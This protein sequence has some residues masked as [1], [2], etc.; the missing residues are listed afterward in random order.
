M[1]AFLGYAG[2]LLRRSPGTAGRVTGV[3][4][5]PLFR[6]PPSGLPFYAPMLIA[7]DTLI[8]VNTVHATWKNWRMEAASDGKIPEL[9]PWQTRVAVCALELMTGTLVAASLLIHRSRTA[10]LL[11]I[12][13]PQNLKARPS[14]ANRRIFIQSAGN[15]R[16]NGTIFPLSICNLTR[17]DKKVLFLQVEG[18]YGGW[19][20]N[21]DDGATVEGNPLIAAADIE[22]A[23]RVVGTQWLQAGGKGTILTTAT[24]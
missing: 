18:Q 23:C 4:K 2:N 14:A 20:F 9:R 16:A 12:L 6:R 22:K 17:V 13:P 11:S 7:A 24:L 1:A 10:T 5:A 8:I 15:W 21:L 3:K 19:Q